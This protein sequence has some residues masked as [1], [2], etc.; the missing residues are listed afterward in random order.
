[1]PVY[2]INKQLSQI[3]MDT[4]DVGKRYK[5]NLVYNPYLPAG[6]KLWSGFDALT[7]EPVE[8]YYE[9]SMY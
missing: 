5:Q 8:L 6:T 9:V 2:K 1:M 7:G 4:K 3:T